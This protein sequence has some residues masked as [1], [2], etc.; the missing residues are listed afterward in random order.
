MKEAAIY[1]F[2]ML[3]LGRRVQE[4]GGQ[5]GVKQ[6]MKKDFTPFSYLGAPWRVRTDNDI[7]LAPRYFSQVSMIKP[8]GLLKYYGELM[9]NL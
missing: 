9:R 5:W 8:S 6:R 1:R 7:I 3:S 2:M 4:W